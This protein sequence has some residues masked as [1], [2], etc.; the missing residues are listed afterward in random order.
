MKINQLE[1]N[2]L[3]SFSSPTK[4]DFRPLFAK[5]LFGIFGATGAGKSTILDAMFLSLYGKVL[6]SKN[7]FEFINTF[8]NKTT[9]K[10]NFDMLVNGVTKTYEVTR[11]Y[12]IDRKKKIVTRRAELYS[13]LD[14]TKNLVAKGDKNVT[15]KI[16][17]VIGFGEEEFARFIA[18]P[19][20]QF[21]KFIKDTA[22]N[23]ISTIAKIFSLDNYGDKLNDAVKDM[24]SESEQQKSYIQGILD[25]FENVS[26]KDLDKSEKGLEKLQ[27]DIKSKVAKYSALKK[28][29]LEK[30]RVLSLI[31]ERE[32]IQERLNSLGYRNAD[33][34]RSKHDLAILKT[35]YTLAP[36]YQKINILTEELSALKKRASEL[37][38]EIQGVNDEYL[39]AIAVNDEDKTKLMI[40]LSELERR[41]SSLLTARQNEERLTSL[42]ERKNVLLEN[43]GEAKKELALLEQRR[44][45]SANI[46][47]RS[48]KLLDDL[49]KKSE[50]FEIEGNI[51]T[52]ARSYEA[53]K[54]QIDIYNAMANVYNQKLASIKE[55]KNKIIAE[56]VKDDADLTKLKQNLIK[57]NQSL[58]EL[59]DGEDT[60]Q[61]AIEKAVRTSTELQYM[62]NLYIENRR[63]I[64]DIRAKVDGVDQKVSHLNNN[65]K[66]IEIDLT[67]INKTLTELDNKYDDLISEREK[68]FGE[69]LIGILKEEIITGQKCPVCEGV[70]LQAPSKAGMVGLQNVDD[71][72]SLVVSRQEDV[73]REKEGLIRKQT[74]QLEQIKALIDNREI[75]VNSLNELVGVQSRIEMAYPSLKNITEDSLHTIIDN[76][77]DIVEKLL[78]LTEALNQIRDAVFSK[79]R[80]CVKKSALADELN[81]EENDTIHELSLIESNL[82]DLNVKLVKYSD[83]FSERT[84]KDIKAFE[85]KKAEQ[86]LVGLQQK[87]AIDK[88]I[89]DMSIKENA[90]LKYQECLV[91]VKAIEREVASIHFEL[92]EI[93]KQYNSI[94]VKGDTKTDLVNNLSNIESARAELAGLGSKEAELLKRET[95]LKLEK[96]SITANLVVKSKELENVETEFIGIC[97]LAGISR[98][99]LLKEVVY[100]DIETLEKKV[101]VYEAELD[102]ASD[103]LRRINATLA[104]KHT[105]K[106]EIAQLTKALD[107]SEKEYIDISNKMAFLTERIKNQKQAVSKLNEY[108][109]TYARLSKKIDELI[110]ISKLTSGDKLL[111]YI[112]EEY[113]FDI[114]D[115]ANKYF[116]SL[117]SGRYQLI[118]KDDFIVIDNLNGGA[119]RSVGTLS[120]GETFLASLSMTIAIVESLAV[121][122]A[123]P[124]DFVFLDE[125]FGTLDENSIEMVMGAI[126]NLRQNNFVFGLIT[127]EE[128][129]KDK[130]N[131]RIEVY[132][133]SL[134]QG[135]R[136]ETIL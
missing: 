102:D 16:Q 11:E 7:E 71:K 3:N 30:E 22:K 50:E 33:Y 20:G 5:G 82:S 96:A 65:L 114:T 18:L 98:E 121:I 53:L 105:S 21:S 48:C 62:G 1:L 104:G 24:L 107:D 2:G 115:K 100:S 117:T 76:S 120:G 37:E 108:K 134:N 136:I 126:K 132:K 103:D 127:H 78:T 42:T 84:I 64:S 17:E 135:S 93:E 51:I 90:S 89:K 29:L 119:P 99:E 94:G 124:L 4:I 9:V 73:R 25:Q 81:N 83:L 49:R 23:K 58:S 86:D 116:A 85:N 79:E 59:F 67:S 36:Q 72:I 41:H 80:I 6:R 57:A 118:Y 130:I 19:Q 75:Y 26:P 95:T 123:K 15:A 45:E 39:R 87:E 13:V 128:M 55:E 38:A 101:E 112:T 44:N 63:K 70:V 131:T 43:L 28:D 14:K 61:G 8:T 32:R 68:R 106:E 46:L 122:K 109:A 129:V 27:K 74:E 40:K 12:S 60:A 91:N 77:K 10:L 52:D 110:E 133:D 34:A 92:G 111:K 54:S 31:E 125:G 69:N 47:A 66:G 97:K 56:L 88:I 113:I 35:S